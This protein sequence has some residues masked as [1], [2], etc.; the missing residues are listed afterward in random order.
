MGLSRRHI[1]ILL[2]SLVAGVTAYYAVPEPLP[3]FSRIEF[4]DEVRAGHVRSI[5]IYDQAVIL[6]ESETRGRFRTEFDKKRDAGLPDEMRA[7][8]IE[9]WYS[10]SPPGI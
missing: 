8:R 2:L 4:L 10:Q 7:L 6:S 5:E 1:V 3:E 9:V